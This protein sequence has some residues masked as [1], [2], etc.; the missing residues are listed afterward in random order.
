MARKFW[1]DQNPLGQIFH[2]GR[3]DP[4]VLRE[5][6]GVV[7]SAREWDPRYPPPSPLKVVGVVTDVR[8]RLE[9]ESGP[10]YY[11][12]N[13]EWGTR[14]FVRTSVEPSGM[15]EVLRREIEAVDSEIT[16]LRVRTI[17][18]IVSE[19]SA[20]SRFRALMV[21]SYAVMATLITCF[22]LFG[23][24]TFAMAQRTREIGVRVTLGA[25]PRDIARLVLGQG[26]RLAGVGI[27]VGLLLVVWMTR[28]V[29]SLLYGVVA[30]DPLTLAAATALIFG[31]ALFAAYLPARIAMRVHPIEALRQ[32]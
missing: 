26:A 8:G 17:D 30:L 27:G 28:F 11:T 32:G 24:L 9:G 14:L 23:V 1:P 29:S 22:G 6:L 10:T 21:V 13:V 19:L 12:L 25:A 3:Q 16:V 18:E 5:R 15:A 7:G 20:D 2:W 31:L 4:D